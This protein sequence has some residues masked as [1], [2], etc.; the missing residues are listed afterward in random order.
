MSRVLVSAQISREGDATSKN[1]KKSKEK[2]SPAGYIQIVH[3]SSSIDK[4][5]PIPIQQPL[6]YHVLSHSRKFPVFSFVCARVVDTQTSKQILQMDAVKPFTTAFATSLRGRNGGSVVPP[7][8]AV[9]N[10]IVLCC[11]V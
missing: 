4:V 7:I 3:H 8:L 6:V 9:L 2:S 5:I 1:S 10:C 11:V